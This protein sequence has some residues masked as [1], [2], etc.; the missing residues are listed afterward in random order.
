MFNRS[1]VE[2]WNRARE[3]LTDY[4]PLFIAMTF[5]IGLGTQDG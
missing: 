3:K 1:E 2:E 4:S 5:G